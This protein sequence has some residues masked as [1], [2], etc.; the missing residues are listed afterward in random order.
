MNYLSN[1]L[2]NKNLKVLITF[3]SQTGCAESI[4]NILHKK[5]SSFIYDLKISQLND[6]ENISSFNNFDYVIFIVSTTGDGEFPDNSLK[7]WTKFRRYKEKD[8]DNTEYC[9][10][11]LGSTDYNNFCFSSKC[12]NRRLLRNS[13]KEFLSIEYADDATGLEDIVEPWLIKVEEYLRNKQ[14][15]LQNWFLKSMSS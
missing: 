4:S 13:A 7:F 1:Y 3:G 10:L 15:N 5:L 12:L 8:L 2:S 14:K 11:G 9:I 6:I